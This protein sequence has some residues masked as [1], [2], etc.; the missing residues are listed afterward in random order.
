LSA[1]DEVDFSGT[2]LITGRMAGTVGWE[3]PIRRNAPPGTGEQARPPD[4]R[5][6]L[7]IVFVGFFLINNL[8]QFQRLDAGHFKITVALKTRYKFAFFEFIFADIDVAL[9][10]RAP[11]YHYSLLPDFEIWHCLA[12]IIDAPLH[13]VKD[14]PGNGGGR[15]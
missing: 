2:S 5:Y 10:L 8:R 13:V 12:S 7:F 1:W 11:N 14:C 15:G 3:L 4:V 9:A 6:L